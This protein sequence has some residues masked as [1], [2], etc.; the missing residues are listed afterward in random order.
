MKKYKMFSCIIT[1]DD[2]EDC[3]YTSSTLLENEQNIIEFVNKK[4]PGRNARL[5]EFNE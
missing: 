4:Y 2:G 1:G 5:F 3:K